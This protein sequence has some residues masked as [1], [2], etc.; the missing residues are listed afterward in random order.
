M[1]PKHMAI[2]PLRDLSGPRSM[3]AFSRKQPV[4]ERRPFQIPKSMGGPGSNSWL[5]V[6]DNWS[7]YPQGNHMLNLKAN[8]RR[9]R[10]VLFQAKSRVQWLELS[11]RN[12]TFFHRSLVHEQTRSRIN[13]LR[14]E[15]GRTTTDQ[16]EIGRMAKD[17]FM[18]IL[19]APAPPNPAPSQI[20][21]LFPN[22]ISAETA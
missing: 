5:L 7:H 14:D 12:T 1:A 4:E 10:R 11:D 15:A 17:Y 19:T 6:R 9:R 22:A 18:G 21:T 2:S 13:E 3:S 20:T 16:A 8:L